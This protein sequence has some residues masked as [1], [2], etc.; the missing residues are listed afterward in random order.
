MIQNMC[1]KVCIFYINNQNICE[2]DRS[3]HGLHLVESGKI[4]LEI[5]FLQCL[6]KYF[7]IYLRQ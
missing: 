3:K 6:S 2:V 5:T 4:I 1:K 7:V